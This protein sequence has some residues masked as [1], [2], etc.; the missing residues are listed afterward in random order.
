M[1][2]ALSSHCFTCAI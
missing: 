1:L 2:K